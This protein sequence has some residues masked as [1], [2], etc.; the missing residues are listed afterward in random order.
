MFRVDSAILFSLIRKPPRATGFFGY[1]WRHIG[2][3]LRMCPLD[4]QLCFYRL[5]LL[6]VSWSCVADVP[7]LYGML[8]T[9]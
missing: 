2:A 5:A 4:E 6:L 9:Y 3:L 7:H 8:S 1:L